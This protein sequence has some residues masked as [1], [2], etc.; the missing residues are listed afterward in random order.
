MLV[1]GG[2]AVAA[3]IALALPAVAGAE[4]RT[5]STW[6]FT[7]ASP[8][9]TSLGTTETFG[10]ANCDTAAEADA[11]PGGAGWWINTTASGFPIFRAATTDPLET[12]YVSSNPD[13]PTPHGTSQGTFRIP[14]AAQNHQ[15]PGSDRS[16]VI[17]EPG[18]TIDDETWLTYT[19]P[20]WVNAGALARNDLV[21]SDGFTSLQG[22]GIRASHA[23]ALGGLIRTWE[24]QAGSIRH[25]LAVALPQT[26]MEPI[27]VAPAKG[28]DGNHGGYAGPIPMGQRFAIPQNVSISSLGLTTAAGQAIA[29]AL[30]T[31]GAYVVDTT[32][33][34]AAFY[35]DTGADALVNPTRTV[36]NGD[37]DIRKIARAMRCVAGNSGTPLAP[38]PPPFG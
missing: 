12:I 1:Q 7:A 34:N 27:A 20:T 2:V 5:P 6:P 8:W 17:L 26:R 32:T 3:A 21:N 16:L 4:T 9:N 30:Q 37:S 28:I 36:S 15:D 38:P 18:A 10:P 13:L 29:T 31:Y 33:S 14:M 23:S 25:A 35:A 11:Q 19:Y 24:L 22:A